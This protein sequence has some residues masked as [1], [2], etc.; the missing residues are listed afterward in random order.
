MF[1][2]LFPF[3]ITIPLIIFAAVYIAGCF[4]VEMELFGWITLLMIAAVSTGLSFNVFDALTFVKA[5]V[6]LTLLYIAG[7][8]VF[9]VI[10]S[11]IKWFSYLMKYRS[12]FRELKQKFLAENTFPRNP[13]SPDNRDVPHAIRSAFEKYFNLHSTVTVKVVGVSQRLD[14]NSDYDGDG[15]R[16]NERLANNREKLW[17]QFLDESKTPN[18]QTIPATLKDAFEVFLR[19]QWQKADYTG[20]KYGKKP[21]AVENKAK[22]TAWTAYWPCSMLSTFLNDPVRR[23]LRFLWN[24]FKDQYERLSNYVFRNDTE[25]Q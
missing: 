8:F 3:P 19:E 12:K 24:L 1:F 25:L 17:I 15:E 6:G 11:F 18:N 22:I 2:F 14:V 16:Y 5:N 21:V 4:L 20:L 9:G 7:Y 13:T 23:I 10:W